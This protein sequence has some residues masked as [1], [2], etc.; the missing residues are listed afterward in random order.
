MNL[1][2]VLPLPL[3]VLS[4]FSAIFCRMA[5]LDFRQR[6]H[7][8]N[9]LQSAGLILRGFHETFLFT[10]FFAAC[11]CRHPF[12]LELACIASGAHGADCP[13]SFKYDP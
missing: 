1:K 7:K 2:L 10:L 5:N 13:P 4:R 9:F 12:F 6:S 11:S 3:Q 8:T